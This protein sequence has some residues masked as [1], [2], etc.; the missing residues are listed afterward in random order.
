MQVGELRDRLLGRV[1]EVAASGDEMATAQVTSYARAVLIS[2][3]LQ[4]ADI[5]IEVEELTVGTRTAALIMGRHPEYVRFLI[6]SK[7]LRA[8]K[9][10]GEFRIPLPEVVRSMEIGAQSDLAEGP[11]GGYGAGLAGVIRPWPSQSRRASGGE[12]GETG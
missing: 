6:R 7:E 1:E 12:S 2:M 3:A 8:T 10:N 5:E 4:P 11:A 9:T